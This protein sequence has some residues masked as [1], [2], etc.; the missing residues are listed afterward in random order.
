[1]RQSYCYL[2]YCGNRTYIGATYNPHIRL[3]Q[4]NGIRSGGARATHGTQWTLAMYVSGFPDWNTT[5]SF[6]WAWK[7]ESRTTPGVYGKIGGLSRLI[8]KRRPTSVSTPYIYWTHGVSLYVASRF[9]AISEKIEGFR[10]LM[11]MFVPAAN[12][13]QTFLPFFQPPFL[14]FLTMSVTSVTSNAVIA[15][16]Q[17]VEELSLDV[18][19]LQTRLAEILERLTTVKPR[20]P[21]A[22]AP[23][24]AAADAPTDAPTEATATVKKPRKPRAKKADAAADAPVDTPVNNSTE[25]TAVAKKP[26]KPRAKKVAAPVVPEVAPVVP[27]VAPVVP[28]VAPVVPEVAPVVPEVAPVVPEVAPVVPEVAPVVPEVAPVVPEVAPVVPEVAPVV[29]EVASDASESGTESATEQKAK[30]P[31]K[32]RAKKVPADASVADS[33]TES[34]T[35]QQAKKPRKPR[36]KKAVETTAATTAEP[37]TAA[38]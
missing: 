3:E 19:S 12:S 6:E 18:A 32:P 23:T 16:S 21:R 20:K 34:A 17:K 9:H 2:L 35:E 13:L 4:H 14:S 31:R 25:G 37:T 15:L 8:Q 22:D 10:R 36:A 1:M 28:E 27:E 24:D 38:E 7:R 33:G 26:R 30:K 5:L 11:S 29:P